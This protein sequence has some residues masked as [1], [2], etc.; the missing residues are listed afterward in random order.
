MPFPPGGADYGDSGSFPT[1]YGNMFLVNF[2]AT[3]ASGVATVVTAQSASA[4]TLI[5]TAATT[6]QYDLTFPNGQVL[7]PNGP[8]NIDP[9]TN[10]PTTQALLATWRALSVTAG[11][12]KILFLEVDG[13][14]AVADPA[15]TTILYGSFWVGA[16]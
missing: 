3:F 8:P 1:K 7:V 5:K 15:D 9:G 10:T 16:F 13:T 12:G 14:P 2:Q 11:T 6:G 4:V